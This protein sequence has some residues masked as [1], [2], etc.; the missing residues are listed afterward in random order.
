MKKEADTRSPNDI[1]MKTET[2]STKLFF[3]RRIFEFSSRS[4][5]IE[6]SWGKKKTLFLC[7]KFLE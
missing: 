5:S 7:P 4:P 2:S 6:I 3:S 1:K